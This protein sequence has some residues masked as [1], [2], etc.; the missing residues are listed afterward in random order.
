LCKSVSLIPH[1]QQEKEKIASES[2]NKS[3]LRKRFLSWL[4]GR[5][6]SSNVGVNGA[7]S[8]QGE[9]KE[10]ELGSNGLDPLEMISST[11]S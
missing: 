3:G 5:K 7:I 6:K 9:G 2:R 8:D 1:A 11:K 4:F 10:S